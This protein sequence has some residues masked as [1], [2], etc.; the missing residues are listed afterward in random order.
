MEHVDRVAHIERLAP[1]ERHCGA[2]VQAEAISLIL[3][4]NGRHGVGGKVGRRRDFGDHSS[5]GPSELKRAIR[6]ALELV[7]FFVDRAV[8][9]ATE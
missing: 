3:R 4:P 6:P 7:A 8:V 9:P 2:S 5:I 1:P